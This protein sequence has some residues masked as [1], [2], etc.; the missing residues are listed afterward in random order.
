MKFIKL[1]D[2]VTAKDVYINANSIHCVYFDEKAKVT[3]I[4][5]SNSE[6]YVK[7]SVAEVYQLIKEVF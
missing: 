1:H 3:V 2:N 5:Y 7:E 6:F 4:D